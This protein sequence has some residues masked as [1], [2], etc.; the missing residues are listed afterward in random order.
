MTHAVT[1][2]PSIL[3]GDFAALGG[4]C[5]ALAEAGADWVHVDVMDGHFVPNLTFGPQM[6][7]AL[8]PHIQGTMDVHLMIAPV[9]AYIGAFAQAGADVITAHHEAGPHIHRTLQ[10][11]RAAGCKAGLAVNPGTGIDAVAHLL[12]EVDLLCVMT[13]NPGFGGQSLIPAMLDKVRALRALIADR[14]IRLQ[15]DGGVSLKTARSLAQAGADVMVAGSAVFQG[16]PEAYGRNIRAL[17]E[18]AQGVMA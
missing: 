4:E 7:A 15:V 5:R 10:A 6:C 13:V 18:A 14:P 3:S 2:A 8:R 12:D 16:G 11:I 17:R 9:D 1:I